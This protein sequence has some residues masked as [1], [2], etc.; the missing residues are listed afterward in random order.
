NERQLVSRQ[1]VP[2]KLDGKRGRQFSG[3]RQFGEA[4]E[5]KRA[6]RQKYCQKR[7]QHRDTA[8]HGVDKKLRGGGPPLRAAPELD[9]EKCRHQAKLPENKPVKEI[10]SGERAEQARLQK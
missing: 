9:Q 10:Q 5:V 8:G 2:A 4:N 6:G 1:I 3:A 7:K